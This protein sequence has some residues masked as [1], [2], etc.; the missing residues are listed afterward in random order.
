[1]KDRKGQKKFFANPSVLK[2]AFALVSCLTMLGASVASSGLLDVLVHER[3]FDSFAERLR[4][5]MFPRDN[6]AGSKVAS[7]DANAQVSPPRQSHP[8]RPERDIEISDEEAMMIQAMLALA[9]KDSGS[10]GHDG[11][12]FRALCEALADASGYGMQLPSSDLLNQVND[13]VI[14][15]EWHVWLEDLIEFVYERSDR[16]ELN[17]EVK[18]VIL[19]IG[20]SLEDIFECMGLDVEGGG[21]AKRIEVSYTANVE[22]GKDAIDV[23]KV[24]ANGKRT[25]TRADMVS[26]CG[27]ILVSIVTLPADL[28]NVYDNVKVL[29][30][31][32]RADGTHTLGDACYAF[33]NLTDSVTSIVDTCFELYKSLMMVIS[34]KS[35]EAG[36]EA[37]AT[38][39]SIAC[40]V[41]GLVISIVELAQE[42]SSGNPDW[43]MVAIKVVN[44][45]SCS[46]LLIASCLTSGAVFLG[47]SSVAWTGIGLIL[48]VIA[49]VA[50]WIYFEYEKA[51][52]KIKAQ[53]DIESA[54]GPSLSCLLAFKDSISGMNPDVMKEQA[55]AHQRI[56]KYVKAFVTGDN[57]GTVFGLIA[58]RINV[59][60]E[61]LAMYERLLAEYL[62][63]AGPAI[64][65]AVQ[66][67]LYYSKG[68]KTVTGHLTGYNSTRGIYS[69]NDGKWFNATLLGLDGKYD[70]R[71]VR[72]DATGIWS[73]TTFADGTAARAFRQHTPV[74]KISISGNTIFVET[75]ACNGTPPATSAFDSGREIDID[76]IIS[77]TDE[78]GES[79]ILDQYE[80]FTKIERMFEG[81]PPRTFWQYKYYLDTDVENIPDGWSDVLEEAFLEAKVSVECI[82]SM[83]NSINNLKR[84]FLSEPSF[85]VTAS[86]EKLYY[87]KGETASVRINYTNLAD[88][89]GYYKYDVKFKGAMTGRYYANISGL[90][91]PRYVSARAFV[92]DI[93]RFTVPQDVA[94]EPCTLDIR[95]Y[96]TSETTS[97]KLYPGHKYFDNRNRDIVMY[98]GAPV[99]VRINYPS[100]TSPG[101]AGRIPDG[102][103]RFIMGVSVF[104]GDFMPV[105]DLSTSNF[106][107][108]INNVTSSHAVI[109]GYDEFYVLSVMPPPVSQSGTYDL[110]VEL[111]K[112]GAEGIS[113]TKSGAV[114]YNDEMR[115]N[116]SIELA[117]VIDPSPS[118]SDEWEDMGIIVPSIISGL[119]GIGYNVTVSI[120]AISHMWNG[121]NNLSGVNI[122]LVKNGSYENFEWHLLSANITL[123]SEEAFAQASAYLCKY[124]NWAQGTS[125]IIIPISDS[126]PFTGRESGMFD[127]RDEIAISTAIKRAHM[128]NVVYFPLYGI[129]VLA[130]PHM[131][132]YEE[133]A[134][135][136]GG[137]ATYFYNVEQVI[138]EIF[139]ISQVRASGSSVIYTNRT[140]IDPNETDE[141]NVTID[142]T[143]D[144]A[145]FST[146]ING[147]ELNISLEGPG[148]MAITE[149]NFA[150]FPNVTFAHFGTF[151]AFVVKN[152]TPG[153][154]KMRVFGYNVTMNEPYSVTVTTSSELSFETSISSGRVSR[155]IPVK[156]SASVIAN[157]GAVLET[158]VKAN[159][160][161][162]DGNLSSLYLYDDGAHGDKGMCDGIF[163][164]FFDDTY[165]YGRYEFVVVATG[166]YGGHSFA[167]ES[168]LFVSVSS[169]ASLR[170]P[171]NVTPCDISIVGRMGDSGTVN[172]VVKSSRA[173]MGKVRMSDFERVITLNASGSDEGCAP[174]N[175]IIPDRG[176]LSLG[177]GNS[178]VM[179]LDYNIPSTSS[180]GR[181]TGKLFFEESAVFSVPVNL[182]ILPLEVSS[183]PK[184]IN[185][186]H[187][188]TNESYCVTEVSV[189]GGDIEVLETFV[190]G[191]IANWSKLT[192][193]PIENATLSGSELDVS[194]GGR[195][196]INLIVNASDQTK[197]GIYYG[198]IVV[199]Y[200]DGCSLVI[201]VRL[202]V[203]EAYKPPLPPPPKP[204]RPET[205]TADPLAAVVI[206]G[207]L[208]GVSV[209]V[210]FIVP[211]VV[212]PYFIR[213]RRGSK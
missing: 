118:M 4:D 57:Q 1:M 68:G 135:G 83:V 195:F 191:E 47:L 175:C 132:L 33:L 109:N 161:Y 59:L 26:G 203:T 160:R 98:L 165:Q 20:S 133:M 180:P 61:N 162:P 201:P 171:L 124:H 102:L 56:A 202:N 184:E 93:V 17:D 45:A 43:V 29:I 176:M 38:K 167:R 11:K 193:V 210:G 212:V 152:V 178:T 74:D 65:E 155:G 182:T 143:A 27:V 194:A 9:L 82:A 121:V 198:T 13:S 23:S 30:D 112:N 77:P 139:T 122:A 116:G 3:A 150:Q 206:I 136:S 60:F 138:G 169:A 40:A 7:S 99:E 115:A 15:D 52:A 21:Q 19:D 94:I 44:V 51:Q 10:A 199:S 130:E 96:W 101:F 41:I 117:F 46:A 84:D 24:D 14:I 156:L 190:T 97:S 100:T 140:N 86:P 34:S 174:M 78:A 170:S 76:A 134:Y 6:S 37:L 95:F 177:K 62:M 55:M 87:L 108:R 36:L 28:L 85:Y 158:I 137:L 104:Q 205:N 48:A 50:L 42:L 54:L 151:K 123:A 196:A 25:T 73:W 110:S 127:E 39:V 125:R 71:E 114:K 154:W 89:S 149:E 142:E 64:D 2:A 79:E 185:S 126:T 70:K 53:A 16:G 179:S 107:V 106:K 69:L 200:G 90:S 192:I 148:G 208:I 189:S 204:N 187:N 159:V 168:E 92:S 12:K 32:A 141:H 58:R 172:F 35:M 197:S 80:L 211:F 188:A 147:S 153:A 75:T 146:K 49:I 91:K 111:V 145:I 181:Y 120:Y 63:L 128:Y 67:S 113:D 103:S 163:A 88:T 66:K 22:E 8:P 129:E 164:N 213:R 31:C 166:A 119:R 5:V 72:A 207:A 209:M 18:D 186:S 173:F 81:G 131:E 105:C 157:S 183:K 144:D